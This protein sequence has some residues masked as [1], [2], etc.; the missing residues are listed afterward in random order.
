MLIDILTKKRIDSVPY[1]QQFD[2]MRSRLSD[3]EFQAIV[4]RINELIDAAG[5][6]IATAGWLPGSNWANTPFQPIY[7]RA[8]RRNYDLSA[9]FFGQVVWY[10]VMQRPETWASGRFEKDGVDIG[11]RTYFRVTLP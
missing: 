2:T 5:A 9:R 7:T 4:D 11:S 10:T 6:E 8:A 3:A 1:R